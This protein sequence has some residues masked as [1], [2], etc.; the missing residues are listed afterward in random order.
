MQEVSVYDESRDMWRIYLDQQD[1]KSAFRHC[2]SQV[3]SNF[4]YA[5]ELA[6]ADWQLTH[7]P[8]E[9]VLA[10]HTCLMACFRHIS[11]ATC[12]HEPTM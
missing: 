7:P 5:F 4:A 11:Q 3:R 12:V 2:K 9:G 6:A 10:Q 8:A 1:Y